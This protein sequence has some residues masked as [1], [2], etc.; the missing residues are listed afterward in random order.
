MA[1]KIKINISNGPKKSSDEQFLK[2]SR[3]WEKC[4][5]L[6]TSKNHALTVSAVSAVSFFAVFR[7]FT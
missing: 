4:L 3:D 6:D 1:E 5:A 2:A 7:R